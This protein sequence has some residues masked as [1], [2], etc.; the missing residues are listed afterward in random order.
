MSEQQYKLGNY[1]LSLRVD[2]LG[3]PQLGDSEGGANNCDSDE[4]N[5][6]RSTGQPRTEA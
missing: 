2:G 3:S 5:W 1:D 4:E 6:G